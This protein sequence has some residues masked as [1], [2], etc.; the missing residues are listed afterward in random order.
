[1]FRFHQSELTSQD[2]LS[3]FKDPLIP[4]G[5]EKRQWIEHGPSS[6][7]SGDAPLQFT[8]KGSGN[9]Y[10]DLKN[11][12]LTVK[13]KIVNSEGK[14]FEG[15]VWLETAAV[16]GTISKSYNPKHDAGPINLWLHS[17]FSQVDLSFHQETINIGT[18]YPYRAYLETLCY[19]YAKHLLETELFYKDSPN[20]MDAT[21]IVLGGNKGLIRR[22]SRT[23]GNKECDMEG[24][25]HLDLCLQERYLLNKV[26]VN[27]KFWHSKD[28]F[29]IMSNVGPCTI[30]IVEAA[31]KVCKIDLN[32]KVFE[33][34][35]NLL[36]HHN[37]IYPYMKTEMKAV[38]VPQG[39]YSCKIDDAFQNRVPSHLV[40]GL[41]E[42]ESYNGDF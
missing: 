5:Y 37:A 31:L 3:L 30:E 15:D 33:H 17:L 10:I 22:A 35:E 14:N 21:Q 24:N 42:T 20:A 38:D 26:D 27:L 2:G 11:S 36:L 39:R 40:F 34:H 41:V 23:V 13:V 6:I 32:E 29:R 25:L 18:M 12:T 7:L 16:D 8:I 9:Q 4:L 28:S 19:P 1:M